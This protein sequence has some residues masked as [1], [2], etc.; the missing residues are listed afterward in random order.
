MA[1]SVKAGLEE[2]GGAGD[3]AAR[4]DDVGL[5]EGAG[6]EDAGAV[7]EDALAVVLGGGEAEMRGRRGG[8]PVPSWR[9]S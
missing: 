1:G 5:L 6:D 3:A 4:A 2:V 7:G 9:V 8:P